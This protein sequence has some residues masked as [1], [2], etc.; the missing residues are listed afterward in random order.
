MIDSTP[1]TRGSVA[2][3]TLPKT[4]TSRTSVIGRAMSSARSRS[5]SSVSA[6]SWKTCAEPPTSTVS[7]PCSPA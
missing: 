1:V 6:I 3:T 5:R 4:A 2:A 7:G